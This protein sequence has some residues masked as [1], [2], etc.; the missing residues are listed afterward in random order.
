MGNH[1][2]TPYG[3]LQA[4][5]TGGVWHSNSKRLALASVRWALRGILSSADE[6]EGI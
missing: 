1:Q 5:M 3:H 6:R 2:R 4:D